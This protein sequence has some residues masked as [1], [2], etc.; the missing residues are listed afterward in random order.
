MITYAEIRYE[1][2]T[3]TGRPIV[4]NMESCEK[5]DADVKVLS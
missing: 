3:K 1:T 2:W 4:R 5:G